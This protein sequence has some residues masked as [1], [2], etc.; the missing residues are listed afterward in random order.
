MKICIIKLGAL[1]DV[2]RTLSI[3]PALKEA[4][5]KSEITWITKP[6]SVGVFENNPFAS[7]VCAIPFKSSEEFD[8]L[9]NFDID[10]QATTLASDI[11]AKKK[12]GFY[13]EGG[14]P[15]AFNTG[16]EYYLNTL[17][18]DEIK[19]T[20]TKS[21]QEMMFDIAELEYKKQHCPIFLNSKDKEYAQAFIKKN[22][23]KGAIVGIHM[24]ASPR[25][26]SKVWHPDCVIEFIKK[27]KEKNY[28]ILLFAGPDEIEDQK[29]LIAKL[30]ENK[31]SIA[32]N[33][34]HNTIK[35]F[36]SLVDLCSVVICSDSLALHV[37][38]ALKKPTI[39]LFFCTPPNEV[40]GYGLL[41]KLVAPRLY[42]FFPEKM[43]QY[44][45]KL[46]KSITSEEV[47]LAVES[48]VE[49]N[50]NT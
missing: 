16:A 18:D 42:E 40:E 27:A 48:T 10:E 15:A 50:K 32:S 39:G 24:G 49:T 20:N 14:Y 8:A 37:S 7:K 22:N 25:W 43:D 9:Y 12:Y 2:V 45:E 19:K 6:S 23:I 31:L 26:P 47:L 28:E 46:V 41:T 1:G 34:P 29:A 17:F 38:L 5:P 11:N 13:A 4:F 21:Y 30:H 44:D 36:A 35:Q 33:N 3:L